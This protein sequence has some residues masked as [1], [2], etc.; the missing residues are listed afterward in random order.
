MAAGEQE[1]EVWGVGLCGWGEGTWFISTR[2]R[3]PVP[4]EEVNLGICVC[5]L[6]F[7]A[8]DRPCLFTQLSLKI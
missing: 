6:P 5:L 8:L 1:E 7:Q 3:A 4:L 2:A